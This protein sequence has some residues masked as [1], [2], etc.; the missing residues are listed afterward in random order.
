MITKETALRI[1]K[2]AEE[3]YDPE[4]VSGLSSLVHVITG[5]MYSEDRNHEDGTKN[6]LQFNEGMGAMES[7]SSERIANKLRHTI[8]ASFKLLSIVHDQEKKLHDVI[9]AYRALKADIKEVTGGKV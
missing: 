7:E 5:W 9:V 6:W 8:N 1:V 4:T 3:Q 2:L